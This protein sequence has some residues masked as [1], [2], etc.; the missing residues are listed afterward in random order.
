[1]VR[2]RYVSHENVL[3]FLGVSEIVLPFGIVSPRMP[4]KNILEYT[5]KH[6]DANRVWLVRTSRI[7]EDK[8]TDDTF[9][10]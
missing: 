2:W 3:P 8:V 10:S 4:N 9:R 1:V 6:L 5:R 7:A